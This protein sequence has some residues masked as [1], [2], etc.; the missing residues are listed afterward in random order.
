[1]GLKRFV[2]EKLSFI[3]Q[4]PTKVFVNVA[5]YRVDDY[6]EVCGAID[7]RCDPAGALAGIE[8]NVSCPN[9]AEGL[10]FGTDARLLQE[11]VSAVRP[12][13]R[14]GKLIVKLSP[15]VTDVAAL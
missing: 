14:R 5:G 11:L 10:M 2:A 7:E 12:V 9:V 6:V 13:V 1:V 4:M 8:L 3:Q 15:N